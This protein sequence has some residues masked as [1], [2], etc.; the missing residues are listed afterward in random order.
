MDSFWFGKRVVVT[1]GAGFVG[2]HLCALLLK[3]GAAVTVLDNFS[4]GSHVLPG[5]RVVKADASQLGVCQHIFHGAEAV[6]NLAAKVAGVHYNQTHNAEMFYL[7]MLLQTVPVMAAQELQ[8]PRFLQVSSVC[9]YGEGYNS[10]CRE[11]N[12]SLG[13]PVAENN[14]YAWAKRIGEK[15][16]H[17][18]DLPHAV[19]V[20]PSNMY[21]PFDNFDRQEELHV[22]PRFINRALGDSPDFELFNGGQTVREFL[23]VEDAAE[24]MLAALESGEPN[25]VYNLGTHGRTAM[26]TA[27]LVDLV[28]GAAGTHKPVRSVARGGTGDAARWSDCSRI[29]ALGWTARTTLADGLR[30]TIE[31]R[32]AALSSRLTILT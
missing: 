4:R 2:R 1:G 8:I 14:G 21:G 18:A 24:G 17:W 11:E 3:H 30:K 25:G 19:I 23:Y 32:Q 15:V 5:E 6:F 9:V 22:I 10:P 7:N 12:G 29:E 28:Q 20:R 13:E 27:E 31:W 16:M 26:T